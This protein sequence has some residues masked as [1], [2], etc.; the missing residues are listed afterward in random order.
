MVRSCLTLAIYICPETTYVQ[1]AVLTK[2]ATRLDA[3]I[4][5]ALAIAIIAN[6]AL[7]GHMSNS[8]RFSIAVPLTIVGFYVSSFLLIGLVAATPKHLP[9]PAGVNRTFSQA[10]YYGILAAAIY[11]IIATMMVF[12]AMGVYIGRY[13]RYF[14]LTTAQRTLMLQVMLFL[15]YMLAAAAVYR[16]I[17]GWQYLDAIYFVDVTLFTM[18]FGDFSP[19][20][21][22]GRGLLFPMAI[23]GILFVGLIIA[24]IRS[25]VLESGSRKVSRRQVEIVRLK[26]LK[27]LDPQK[28]SVR[29]RSFG[30]EHDVGNEPSSELERR[31]QEF[32]LMRE[33]QKRAA[34]NNRLIALGVS[35]GLWLFLWFVGAVC[36][37]QAEKSTQ[38]WSYF[39]ALY[40]T[41][42]SFLTIG[43]GDFYPQNNS[44]KPVF[45]FWSLLALPTLTVLIGAIGDTIVEWVNKTTLFVGEHTLLPGKAGRSLRHGAASKK[46]GEGGEFESSKPPGFM[47]DEEAGDHHFEDETHAKAVQGIAGGLHNHEESGL[48]EPAGH[49]ATGKHL[50]PYLLLKEMRKVI[51]HMD[52]T[53]PRQ[54][55]YAEWTWFL[56]LLNED[57]ESSEGH[58][59]PGAVKDA[60]AVDDANGHAHKQEDDQRER[61][62][63]WSWIGHKSP[64]MQ[65]VDEPKWILERMMDKLEGELKER[66]KESLADE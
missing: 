29:L 41:Y 37:W 52:A 58:R 42:V 61:G 51:Q 17:E 14:K 39:E 57:E 27:R 4:A 12:T 56:K 59:K 63:P 65:S 47:S 1:A 48:N 25:L 24:S 55:T 9:L 31:E 40:F 38:D 15:G 66:G 53:P 20:T 62:A 30:R 13:S 49:E 34:T 16:D 26:T 32:N 23:G 28:G 10:Y 35:G 22:L 50:Q 3:V 7:L 60:Q 5:I 8:V 6:L 43:Y 33:V 36:F 2:G 11:F 44:A 45:V 21:H 64:L 18:G 46:K 54:Y 19:K